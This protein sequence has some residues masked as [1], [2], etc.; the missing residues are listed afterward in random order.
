M[1]AD[2]RIPR[3]VSA[4]VSA[5]P[6]RAGAFHDLASSSN[7]RSAASKMSTDVRIPRSAGA[8]ATPWNSPTAFSNTIHLRYFVDDVTSHVDIDPIHTRIHVCLAREEREL[9]A[10][11]TFSYA[12]GHFSAAQSPSGVLHI[13]VQ[14][15]SLMRHPGDVSDFDEYRRHLP[16]QWCPM[17]TVIGSVP[18]PSD[19][20]GDL[21]EPRRFTVE[22]AVYDSSKSALVA[23]SLPC[24]L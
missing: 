10:P 18:S 15:L 6:A 4:E 12:Q 14:A 22:T 17:V 1:S 9:Y 19:R 7:Y 24:F 23:L 16:G 8:T 13:S 21:F 11:N 3:L 2:V 20:T 5:G